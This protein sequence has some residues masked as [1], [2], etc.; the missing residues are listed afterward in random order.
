MKKQKTEGRPVLR[1]VTAEGGKL[2][3]ERKTQP[4]S[5]KRGAFDR[6]KKLFGLLQDGQYPNCTSI[7]TDFE[8]S[9]KTAA[10]DV[11]FMRERWNLPIGYDDKR[12][13]Y[14]FTEKVERLPWV[15]VTE[16]ELFAVCI[17]QKVLELYH[18]MPFQKPLEL[19]FAKITRSLDDEERYML[20]NLD[21]AFSFRPF[22]P[23]D[24]DLR[25]LELLTRAVAER[26]G[27]RFSY[28]KPGARRSEVRKVHPY[29]VMEYEGRLYLLA[30]DPARGAVRTFVL[31]RMSEPALTGERFSRPKDFNPKKEFST[32]LG[33][34]KGTGDYQVVIEMD[35]WLTDILR[36]RRLHP[37]QVLQEMPGGG[38]RL[39]L[40]LSGLEEIEQYVLSWGTHANVLE[41]RELR[42]RLGV[43]A[44]A[45]AARYGDV[46][47]DA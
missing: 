40:R 5:V 35:A 17:S 7:A 34:M 44:R 26:R 30:H 41:P 27:L 29:H 43:A 36:G 3:S 12:H 33:I 23:E 42:E 31:G 38:S 32:S 37:S 46:M 14:C 25:L 24:P 1:S 16:A 39:R 47:R 21:L 22:A 20:E 10:R 13:G 6:M 15:P 19:A 45:L 2:K 4:N 18:G 11:E 28:R 9:L 8:V